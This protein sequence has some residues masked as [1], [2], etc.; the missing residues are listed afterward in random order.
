MR[1]W[2]PWPGETVAVEVTRPQGLPGQTLTIDRSALSVSPGLRASDATLDLTMRSS[3]GAQHVVTLPV[4]AELQSVSINGVVQPIRQEGRD[5]T[6]P[7]VP[8]AQQVS[9]VWRQNAGIGALFRAPEVRLNAPSVNLRVGVRMPMDRWTLIAGGPRLGPAVLFWSLLAISL[10]ASIAL[11][12]ARLTPLRAHHWFLLSLGLTQAPLWVPI[13]IAAWLFGLGWRRERGQSVV[14]DSGF[15][16]VQVLLA[17]GGAVALSGLFWSISQGLLGLP[18]MQISGNGSSAYELNWY[19]DRSA[20]AFPRPWV[21]SVPL[22][23]Y[24]LAMLAWALWL[25]QA[26]LRWLKWGWSCYSE[27][28]VWRPRQKK[29]PVPPPRVPPAQTPPEASPGI[30]TP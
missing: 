12:R 6:L 13:V 3:R 8:G 27:G 15:D 23:V 22:L 19:Q 24:R 2:R 17:L 10:I 11:G 4:A 21:L 29:H 20:D 7:M 14:S 5:V 25:A 28:G 9:I 18:E 30:V 1:E 26:L 16:G